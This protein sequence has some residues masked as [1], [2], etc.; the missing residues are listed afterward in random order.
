MRNPS[1]FDQYTVELLNRARIDPEGEF[2]RLIPDA[3]TGRGVTPEVTSAILA[4]QFGS[5]EAAAPLAW[6]AALGQS[7]QDHTDQMLSHDAQSHQLPGEA[8][9]GD[10][11]QT[12]GYHHLWRAGENIYAYASDAL[13][14]FAAFLIDWGG[15]DGTGI[16]N[17][18]GHRENIMNAAFTE[19][20]VGHDVDTDPST[21]VGPNLITHDLGTRFDYAAQVTGVVFADADGDRF[22]TMGEGIAGA[23]VSSDGR[24]TVGFDSGGYNLALASGHHSLAFTAP[25]LV[26]ASIGIDLGADNVKVD[27]I[28]AG[29]F[30]SSVSATLEDGAVAL[31]LLGA[32]ARDAIGNALGNTLIGSRGDNVLEGKDGADTLVGGLGN[33]VLDGGSNPEGP[34]GQG[35]VMLGGQGDDTYHVDSGLDLVDEDFVFPGFGNGGTDTIISTTDFYW[36]TQSVGE[37]D[38]VSADVAD[39][40]NDGVTFVGGIFD[41]LLIGHSGTDVLFGRG[42]NDTYRAGDGVDYMSLS[43]L[44]LTDQNAYAGVDGHNTVIVDPR[45]TGAFS[46]DI[47]FEFDPA[48]DRIDVANYRAYASGADVLAHAVDDGSGSCYVALG[49]GLDY[50]Y[51]VGIEKADLTPSDFIV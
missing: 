48:R 30:R 2:A 32:A 16:Q 28:G 6:N 12:A 36:D 26:S 9:L 40:G 49:D 44:G 29:S 31:E 10:R 8:G 17:P 51:L 7:A 35:D 5:L 13:S 43:T 37:I 23:T 11:I 33:D 24:S 47:V 39:V 1:A 20:G 14:G 25:G 46:Y 15:N 50:L 45:Q 4:S 22:Y 3:S 41:N 38:Q 34:H 42:G 19:I 27:L 21:G 18:A